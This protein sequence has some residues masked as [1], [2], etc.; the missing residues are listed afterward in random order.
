MQKCLVSK[1]IN[2]GPDSDCNNEWHWEK[3]DVQPLKGPRLRV[4]TMRHYPVGRRECDTLYSDSAW[5][6]EWKPARAGRGLERGRGR[7]G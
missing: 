6:A 5:K 3:G 7:I 1:R 2:V 4:N